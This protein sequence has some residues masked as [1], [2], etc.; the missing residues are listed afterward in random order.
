VDRVS[1]NRIG[2]RIDTKLRGLDVV[3]CWGERDHTNVKVG[4]KLCTEQQEGN[5]C[6]AT[7]Q[8]RSMGNN[9]RKRRLSLERPESQMVV[10]DKGANRD[11]EEPQQSF[12][13]TEERQQR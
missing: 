6:E 12:D 11:V 1:N 10:R 3:V 9:A 7:R 5:R 2:I 8:S 13:P 4:F